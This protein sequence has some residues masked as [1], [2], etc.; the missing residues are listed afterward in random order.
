MDAKNIN[1]VINSVLTTFNSALAIAPVKSEVFLKNTNESSNEVTALI[2]AK[3]S[4][5]GI[6][7]ISL[8]K[9]VAVRFASQMSKKNFSTF[10][11]AVVDAMGEIINIITGRIKADL[12]DQK[13]LLTPPAYVY[14]EG[15]PM[16]TNKSFAPYICVSFLSPL[17]GFTIEVSLK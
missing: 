11:N 15:K 7:A 13:F 3:G 2:E 14:G 4:H 5:T 6:F 12:A 16:F 10:D 9:P 8:S 1:V 17:G